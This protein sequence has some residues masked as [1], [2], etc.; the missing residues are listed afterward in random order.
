MSKRVLFVGSKKLGLEALK[1]SVSVSSESVCGVVAL[2]D[3]DDPRS[4]LG[5][6]KTYVES[7]RLQLH[8]AGGGKE[9]A[10]I[11]RRLKP[12]LCLVVGWYTLIGN[13]LL[14]AIPDGW[15]G[16]HAS[17]LPRYRGGAPLV[18]AIIQ[19]ERKSGVSL[20]HFADEMDAGPVVGSAEFPI[21][22]TATISDVLLLAGNA[23]RRVVK[24]NLPAVLDGSAIAVA[25][26][27]GSATYCSLRSPNDG[28]IDWS[29][30][31]ATIHNFVRAQ[32][33]PYPGAFGV[34]DSGEQVRIW[35]SAPFERPLLGPV[36]KVAF[37]INGDPIVA[38]GQGTGLRILR[39]SH[40][41]TRG[42]QDV[43]L[44]VGERLL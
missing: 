27:H 32:S 26:D 15:L 23:V 17:L 3:Q 24:D 13:E 38:C 10:A 20:F 16:I 11:V 30:G 1:E 37:C 40:E 19:G 34:S 5:E 36:G 28:H 6:F 21:S 31:A 41:G 7:Q 42:S 43:R 29:K 44:R 12:D 4:V 14:K 2:N 25:Q 9:L 35:E 33:E 18:W 39:A 8:V 22:Q